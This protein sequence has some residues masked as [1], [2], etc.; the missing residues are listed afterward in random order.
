MDVQTGR[1]ARRVTARFA[2]CR[3][4]LLVDVAAAA[5]VGDVKQ[6]AFRRP[7]GAG[8]E[9]SLVRDAHC[10]PSIQPRDPYG[11]RRDVTERDGAIDEIRVVGDEGDLR[12][13]G[14]PH[15]AVRKSAL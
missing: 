15:E 6:T 2:G 3:E 9:S 7:Y 1:D 12:S 14:G 8:V 10:F 5:G 11:A 4:P 13:V